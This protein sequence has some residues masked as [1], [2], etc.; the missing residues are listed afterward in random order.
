M[1][2]P[3]G[4]VPNEGVAQQVSPLPAPPTVL[5]GP[6]HQAPGAGNG[7]WWLSPRVDP[8]PLPQAVQ[9]WPAPGAEVERRPRR[10]DDSGV[11]LHRT[12]GT[13]ALLLA[14]LSAIAAINGFLWA[15]Q[16]H[17]GS[18]TSEQISNKAGGN[19]IFVLL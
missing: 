6:D 4:H 7:E 1:S 9:P 2:Y 3:S 10:P 13:L 5:Y 17:A 12:M 18:G 16:P 19:L 11:M 15:A 8:Y 14:V